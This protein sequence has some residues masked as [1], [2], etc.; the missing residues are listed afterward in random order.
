MLSYTTCCE[1]ENSWNLDKILCDED[2]LY[3]HVINTLKSQGKFSHSLLS[4]E[5]IA[6]DFEVSQ[7]HLQWKNILL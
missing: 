1:I 6:N 7:E 2:T 4:L 5:E 3:R